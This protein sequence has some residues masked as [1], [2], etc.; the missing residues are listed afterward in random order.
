VSA[1]LAGTGW[2]NLLA[3]IA[4]AGKYVAL[5][6]SACTMSGTEFDPDSSSSTGKALIVSLVLPSAA[7]SIKV[8]TYSDPTFKYFTA[9]KTVSGEN[10]TTVGDYAF[11]GCTAL[12][13]VSLPQATSIGEYAFDGCTA[14]TSVDLP[15]A[16]TIG[17]LY[18]FAY[19][20]ALTS[21]SLP[22]A[23][24]IG[25]AAFEGC[26][27]LTSVSLPQA[28]TIRYGAFAYTGTGLLAVTLG[29]VAP[30]VDTGV[31][32][33]VSAKTVT[34]KVPSTSGYGTTSVSGSDITVCWANGFRGAGWYNS[35][36][37]GDDS[38]IN[39]NITV[40][41]TVQ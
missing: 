17:D 3:E 27:A 23:T 21:V 38:Y 9:L 32:F 14:L 28:Q 34:V 15:R 35:A 40:T 41:I 19:C 1:S 26:T 25:V 36:F 2:S 37:I 22:Q 33:V 5:D 10:I 16:E 13:S 39:Q 4:A 20:T 11:K 18:A 30:T 6:L 8:G 31:F 12:T 7:T 24:Y 29:G